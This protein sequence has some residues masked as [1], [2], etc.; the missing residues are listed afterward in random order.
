MKNRYLYFMAAAHFCNDINTGALP[1]LLPFYVSYYG[2]D[3]T[4][5]AGLLF[6][7][8]FLSSVI[9]PLFGYLADRKSR[10]WFMGFGIMVTGG[11]LGITGLLQNYWAIFTAITIM[12]IGSSIFHPEAARLVNALAGEKKG[13]AMSIFSVGGNAGFGVGPLLVVFLITNFGLEGSLFFCALSLVMGALM[14]LF[15]K[16]IV[17][18]ATRVTQV[19]LKGDSTAAPEPVYDNDWPNF[20]KLTFVIILRS[21]VSAGVRGFLPLFCIQV[22]LAS[23]AVGTATLSLLSVAGIFATL[24]GGYLADRYGYARI[25]KIGTICMVPILFMMVYFENIA[26]VYLLL[27]P[28]SL[29]VQGTYSSFVVMGQ[30]YLSKNVGFASGITLGI[31]FSAGGMLVP[32]IGNYADH[33]G[34]SQAMWLIVIIATLCALGS[35]FLP[36]PKSLLK[37]KAA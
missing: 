25:L 13:K 29:S 10:Q 4:S 8:S 18:S 6:A 33:Y 1:A 2:M 24:I 31:S 22:I 15:A 11:F 36:E 9:Q 20:G 12:G 37:K 23:H 34:I 30:S 14:L 21:T 27:I 7:G 17:N 5:I 32:V 35:Q 19:D 16:R 26:V 28:L 3:Y